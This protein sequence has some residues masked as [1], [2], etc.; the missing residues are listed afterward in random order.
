MPLRLIT[1]ALEQYGTVQ[2]AIIAWEE[3]ARRYN[4]SLSL[5]L[6]GSLIEIMEFNESKGMADFLDMVEKKYGDKLKYIFQDTVAARNPWDSLNLHPASMDQGDL[7]AFNVSGENG[8]RS[9]RGPALTTETRQ[10]Q[11][12]LFTIDETDAVHDGFSDETERAHARMLLLAKGADVDPVVQAAAASW[13]LVKA[14]VDRALV[15]GKGSGVVVAVLDTGFDLSHPNLAPNLWTNTKEVANCKDDDDN[16]VQDDLHGWDFG[17]TCVSQAEV[18]KWKQ[19]MPRAKNNCIFFNTAELKDCSKRQDNDTSREDVDDGHGTHVAGIVAATANVDK[20]VVGA[21]PSAQL[22]LLKVFTR[23]ED[24]SLIAYVSAIIQAYAYAYQN[25]ANI[26]VCSFGPKEVP[27][28]PSP[29]PRISKAWTDWGN[30]TR[31][32][33][34]DTM[35]GFKEKDILVVAAA[36]NEHTDLN[37]V[38][39]A[40]NSYLPCTLGLLNKAYRDYTLSHPVSYLAQPP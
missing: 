7:P 10:M 35:K 23:L 3:Q 30:Y 27:T 38:V 40:N 19:L 34:E 37:A 18:D 9:V 33:Y 25:G 8:A 4:I 26:V 28:G 21:A 36:G 16:F 39:N 32:T 24:K 14:G 2:T 20:G 12:S 31:M 6:A 5:P 11:S 17:G 15:H 22:M 29:D 13:H 1:R